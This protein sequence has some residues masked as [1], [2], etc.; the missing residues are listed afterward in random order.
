MV[1]KYDRKVNYTIMPMTTLQNNGECKVTGMSYDKYR[2]NEK[3]TDSQIVWLV[4]TI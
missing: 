1:H 3:Q 4:N 2:D